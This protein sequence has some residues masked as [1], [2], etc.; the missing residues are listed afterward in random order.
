VLNRRTMQRLA[1]LVDDF[2]E[3][4]EVV[5]QRVDQVS[6]ASYAEGSGGKE[7]FPPLRMFYQRRLDVPIPCRRL[8]GR[9]PGKYLFIRDFRQDF[10][11]WFLSACRVWT[12]AA[13]AG[14]S[15]AGWG[16]AIAGRCRKRHS[17]IAA[18][19][20]ATMPKT[21]T[22]PKVR[23]SRGATRKAKRWIAPKT[24]AM[25]A[26]DAAPAIQGPTGFQSTGNHLTR[27]CFPSYCVAALP[28]L[29][30]YQGRLRTEGNDLAQC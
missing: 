20:A 13:L 12:R 17:E 10:R 11:P 28:L 19:A 8:F 23:I 27:L 21:R 5:L 14:V 30:D 26:R 22:S 6:T 9:K 1:H 16:G 18:F 4:S 3:G 2:V 25:A 15:G 7:V 24:P 29:R